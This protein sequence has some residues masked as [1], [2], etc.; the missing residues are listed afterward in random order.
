[1]D[2]LMY[3]RIAKRTRTET[4]YLRAYQCMNMERFREYQKEFWAAYE[5]VDYRKVGEIVRDTI[6][7]SN[8]TMRI[9]RKRRSI[10]ARRAF[11]RAQ[12]VPRDYDRQGKSSPDNNSR[13]PIISQS[14]P[15]ENVIRLFPPPEEPSPH[16]TLPAADGAGVAGRP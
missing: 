4:R 14:L 11:I 1:M 3:E 7:I 12:D 6:Q 2:D 9:I 10:A 8:D 13:V 15:A 16:P 5:R